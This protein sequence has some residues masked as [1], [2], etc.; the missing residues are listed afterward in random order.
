MNSET[1]T[2]HGLYRNALPGPRKHARESASPAENNI[3][4]KLQKTN[5]PVSA[6]YPVLVQRVYVDPFDV[7]SSLIMNPRSTI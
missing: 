2:N 6:A 4:S 5:E 3:P 1:I 7:T